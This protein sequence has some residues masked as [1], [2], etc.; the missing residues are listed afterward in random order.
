M[1]L[2]VK[3][4]MQTQDVKNPAYRNSWDC[5]KAILKEG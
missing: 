5:C 4:V 1:L 3:V 2:Q